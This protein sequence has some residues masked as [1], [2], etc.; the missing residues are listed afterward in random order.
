MVEVGSLRPSVVSVEAMDG[1]GEA[2][3][4]LRC[5]PEAV[6]SGAVLCTALPLRSELPSA[7]CGLLCPED[8]WRSDITP[9]CYGRF[10]TPE[11][12]HPAA[13]EKINVKNTNIGVSVHLRGQRNALVWGTVCSR[14]GYG[15]GVGSALPDSDGFHVWSL[16]P[17]SPRVPRPQERAEPWEGCRVRSFVKIFSFAKQGLNWAV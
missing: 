17:I 11:R 10:P 7:L 12:S 8:E 16:H 15:A 13:M 2:Q 4:A 9:R 14:G 5:V 3:N 1:D 6:S